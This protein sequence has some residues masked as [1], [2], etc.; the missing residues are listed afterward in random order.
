MR[1]DGG[2]EVC[3]QQLFLQ[4]KSV[5]TESVVPLKMKQTE[6]KSHF[7]AIDFLETILQLL[8]HLKG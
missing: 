5:F 8:F 3:L 1:K 2:A 6:A 4:L 7:T